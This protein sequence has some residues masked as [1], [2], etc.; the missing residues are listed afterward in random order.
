MKVRWRGR[1]GSACCQS[2]TN[3]GKEF[4]SSA[5]SSH[6][7]R[8]GEIAAQAR[9]RRHDHAPRQV[10]QRTGSRRNRDVAHFGQGR[11]GGLVEIALP[12]A[13][14]QVLEH[15]A[16]AVAAHGDARL[17]TH[18][19]HQIGEYCVHVFARRKHHVAQLL[20]RNLAQLGNSPWAPESRA[21]DSPRQR[22]GRRRPSRRSCGDRSPSSHE[23]PHEHARFDQE[24]RLAVGQN[25]DTRQRRQSG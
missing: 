11:A 19:A 18:C 5:G 21:S 25:R 23:V 17:S 8:G 3:T 13:T 22:R 2:T 4:R 16:Q 15:V 1:T 7:E 12:V 20:E 9:N 24:D 6:A 10:A 14:D